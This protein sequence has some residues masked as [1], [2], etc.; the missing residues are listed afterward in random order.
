MYDFILPDIGEGISEALLIDWSVEPGQQVNEGDEIATVSTDKVDV[1]LPSPRAG[2]VAE[3][4]W[5]PGDTIKVGAVFMRIDTGEQDDVSAEAPA[6]VKDKA[7]AKADKPALKKLHHKFY[8]PLLKWMKDE[9]NVSLVARESQ[10]SI[11]LMQDQAE[12]AKIFHLVSN[13]NN[14]DNLMITSGYS[15]DCSRDVHSYDNL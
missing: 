4:C 5:K 11:A 8:N 15:Y 14:P 13:P 3:L 12:V 9:H 10:D 7:V 2:T 1:E 6:S